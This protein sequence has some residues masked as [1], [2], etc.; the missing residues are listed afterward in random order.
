MNR[1]GCRAAPGAIWALALLSVHLPMSAGA[2]EIPT[3]AYSQSLLVPGVFLEHENLV[4]QFP[5]R[6]ARLPSE[7]LSSTIGGSTYSSASTIAAGANARAGRH[8][9][10]LLSQQFAPFSC[11][12]TLRLIQ[13]GWAL[14]AGALAAGVALRGGRYRTDT[15]N[16]DIST[17]ADLGWGR[18][19]S[20]DYREAAL[21]I[22]VVGDGLRVDLAFEVFREKYTL[23]YHYEGRGDSSQCRLDP[24]EVILTKSFVRAELAL[25]KNT[26][27]VIGG[28]FRE[29][30]SAFDITQIWIEPP[31]SPVQH[32]RRESYY[33]HRWEGGV[34]LRKSLSRGGVGR[35]FASYTNERGTSLHGQSYSYAG[36][37]KR[38]SSADQTISVGF[39][40][41]RA[42]WWECT[43]LAGVRSEFFYSE[44]RSTEEPEPDRFY[45]EESV[46]ETFGQRFAWGLS[47]SF[48]K[49]TLTGSVETDLEISDPFLSLDARL[50]F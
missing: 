9:F 27:L 32:H 29:T 20:V 6:A 23:H 49:L 11:L 16:V 36:L 24:Q 13:G 21:G 3:S 41:E 22:G 38:N 1:N 45:E 15:E 14:D 19:L 8:A 46:Q 17:D 26:S 40:L 44:D 25:S 43:M 28:G 48:Q 47:R 35:V 42:T 5:H 2:G 4:Y 30:S 10:F 39:S 31:A 50:L 18:D 37:L 34:C 7:V 12:S 33:G